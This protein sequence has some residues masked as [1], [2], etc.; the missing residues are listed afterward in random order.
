[1]SMKEITTER[2]EEVYQYPEG[3]GLFNNKNF[4]LFVT[5]Y[6]KVRYI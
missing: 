6:N 3:S 5:L 4:K 2:F 1:M